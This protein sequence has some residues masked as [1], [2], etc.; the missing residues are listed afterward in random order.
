MDLLLLRHAPAADREDWDGDDAARPLT[1]EGERKARRVLRLLR[2]LVRAEAVWTS[3]WAR[4]HATAVIAAEAWSLPLRTQEWLAGGAATPAEAIRLLA[5]A[6]DVV[7]VGHE[8]DL[9]QLAGV[10]LGAP[11]LRLRKAGCA[12]L[13]GEPR[14]GGMALRQ[15]LAPKTVLALGG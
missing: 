2:P 4:A 6:G 9:G 5:R 12:W 3:P 10:L 8:P 7:L 1:A 11:A 14:P 13:R 15:L